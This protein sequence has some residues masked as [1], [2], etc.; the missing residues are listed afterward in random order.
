MGSRNGPRE[1]RAESPPFNCNPEQ[2]KRGRNLGRLSP[3]VPS[4]RRS[5]RRC[6]GRPGVRFGTTGARA[7]QCGIREN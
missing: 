5:S 6:C 7:V 1:I 3:G 2:R 4:G